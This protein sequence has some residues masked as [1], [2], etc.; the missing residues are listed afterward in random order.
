MAAGSLAIL[1]FVMVLALYA[2]LRE[3]QRELQIAPNAIILAGGVVLP[4][5]LLSALLLYAAMLM[6]QLREGQAAGDDDLQIEVIAN[7]WWWEVRYPGKVA[8]DMHVVTA[9]ELYI[10]VGRSVSVRLRSRDVIHSFWIPNLAGKMDVIPG[11]ERRLRLQADVVGRFR[12]QC[13]EFCGAQH[14]RMGL[15]I[16]A[17]PPRAF[18]A[19][20]E[21]MRASRTAPASDAALRGRV[22]FFL[23]AC[24]DCHTVRGQAEQGTSGPDLTHLR[25]RAWIGAGTLANTPENVASWIARSERIKP[26]NRMPSYAHLDEATVAAL[27]A[28]LTEGD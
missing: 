17:E 14:A 1:A 10:P 6:A 24:A 3:P 23:H 13:A 22:A 20:M 21:R 27:A 26:R 28:F 19:R 9:N 12:G 4:V 11:K 18:D 2:A 5:V 16:V 15:L 7:Q 8:S 25:G